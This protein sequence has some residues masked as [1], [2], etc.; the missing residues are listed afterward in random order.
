MRIV[1][2]EEMRRLDRY[3]IEDI[4][5]QVE[6]LM[7]NAG[8]SLAEL[9]LRLHRGEPENAGPVQVMA[10]SEKISSARRSELQSDKPWVI[11]AGKGNNGGDGLVA[12]RHLQEYGIAVSIVLAEE[13]DQLG[14]EAAKQLRS[15][16]R[17]N[18]DCSV[19][20][21]AV[22]D[23]SQWGG[24]VDALL[25]TGTRGEP[26]EPYASLIR[27][28][29][30]SGLPIIAADVPSGLDSDT[31]QAADPCIQATATLTFALA[32]CGLAQHPGAALAGTVLVAPVGIPPAL[33][34]VAAD[35]EVPAISPTWLVTPA[36]LRNKLGVDPQRPRGDDTH[37]GSY[38]HVLVAA[39]TRAMSGAGLL[40]CRAALRS[41]CGLVT[42]ALPERL[43]D[44][45]I[46]IQPELM[47]A[48]IPDFGRGDWSATDPGQLA[49]L[50]ATRDVLVTGPGMG[51]LPGL[52]GAD[53]ALPLYEIDAVAAGIG[54]APMQS[55]L[56]QLW[57]ELPPEMPVVID[58]DALNHL[59][60]A[61]DF[62]DWPRRPG[63]VILT[64]HPGEM[65]RLCGCRT[66]EVQRDRIG[67]ARHYATTN[68][69]I[70][71]L[72]GARTVCADP[73]GQVYVNPTGNP[74]MATGGTGD[75]LAGII[76][77]LL[78]QGHSAMAA[79]VLGVYL[80]GAAGDAAAGRRQSPGSIIAGDLIAEL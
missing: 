80:H 30:D 17:L 31:G 56:R 50:T 79:A 1:Q 52:S 11:L 57:H 25:G 43:L 12:A 23:W 73:S 67:I 64:P 47:L 13:T 22:L 76:G 70:V 44:G 38:G 5:V 4:G 20:R 39:G 37:K 62:A 63:A 53:S 24:I 51:Q 77:G 10:G 69:V 2:S 9:L 7:E 19:Y 68:G 21:P 18:I 8:R 41:G 59:A 60:E 42:W 45:M 34:D 49:E 35:R 15:V 66:D 6:S 58:A 32:K 46:G 27:E 40:C 29:N 65:A 28:A 26:K 55:W 72:K 36:L 71:V 3:V 61:G 33:L 75:V 78:A 48:S 54:K 16:K 74:G 14:A